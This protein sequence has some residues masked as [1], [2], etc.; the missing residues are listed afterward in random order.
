MLTDEDLGEPVDALDA[1]PVSPRDRAERARVPERAGP[2]DDADLG[3]DDRLEPP[4]AA[5][6]IRVPAV[7]APTVADFERTPLGD[8]WAG[9][10][11]G[12]SEAGQINALVRELAVQA[13][14]VGVDEAVQPPT[15][16]LRVARE[17]LRNPALVDKLTAVLRQHLGGPAQL[18][19]AN[20][21]AVD[22]V[23]R[24]DALEADRRQRAAVA[25]IQAAPVVATLLSQFPTARVLPGSIKPL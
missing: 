4:A 6:P 13:E 19:V 12:W 1:L 21:E 20:G 15:W 11:R 16:R 24:R 9:L 5:A 22:C 2:R 17:T 18:D 23:A 3:P 8:R 14:L 7:P 25:A 10:V